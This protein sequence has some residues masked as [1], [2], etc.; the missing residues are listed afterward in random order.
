ML[1][2]V[3]VI[4]PGMILTISG[5]GRRVTTALC[6][7]ISMFIVG[8]YWYVMAM[9]AT[10][11][12]R[13]RPSVGARSTC[14]S[15]TRCRFDPRPQ[16]S[17]AHYITDPS[18]YRWWFFPRLDDAFGAVPADPGHARS[19][20]ALAGLPVPQQDRPG[21]L[22]GRPI[23]AFVYV[24]TP[25]TAAGQEFQPRAVSSLNTGTCCRGSFWPR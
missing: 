10:G 2:P 16:F 24:F 19:G 25:L 6:L 21:D 12:N 20:C 8:G 18:I 1:A 9:L 4:F 3:G 7:G 11:G 15:R 13:C 14:R 17:V 22:R 5:K 23:T